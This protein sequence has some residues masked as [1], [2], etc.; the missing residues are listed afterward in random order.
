MLK[1][2]MEFR[3][4]ILFVRLKGALTK[5]TYKS[6]ED[7]LISVINKHGIKYLIYN[8][9]AVTLIDSYG[10]ASLKKGI[11]A[12]KANLGEGGLCHA[13]RFLKKEFRIF[14]NELAAFTKLQ[15]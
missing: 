1:I 6:L 11:N 7:Y 12:A 15:I 2:N 14:E 5:Y 13:K 9:E 4:G 10:E 3:R 8:L